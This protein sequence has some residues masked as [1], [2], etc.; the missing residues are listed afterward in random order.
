VPWANREQRCPAGVVA[1]LPGGHEE[2]QGPPVCIA[3]G[4]QLG[5]HA[6]FGAADQPPKAP[7]F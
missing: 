2:A 7:P 4:V 5:V 3:D 1:D 6:T